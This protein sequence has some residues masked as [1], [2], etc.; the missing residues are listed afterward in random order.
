M[1]R[2]ILSTLGLA[3]MLVAAAPAQRRTVDDFFRDFTADWIRANPNQA[4]ALRYFTGE[5]QER[6][7]RELTPVNDAHTLKLI[8]LARKGLAELR[9]YDKSAMS[10][11][12]RVSA[13]VLQWQ[14]DSFIQM[15]PFRHIYFPFEQNGGVNVTLPSALTIQHPIQTERDADNYLEKLRQVDRAIDE[16][17]RDAR[18]LASTG[19][20]PPRFILDATI[21]QMKQFTATPPAD[22][23]LAATL[24]ERLAALPNI[25]P[26]KRD[27]VRIRAEGI[28]AGEVY[29]AW[30]RAV[31]FLESIAGR[32]THDAGVWRLPNGAEAYA[33][34][35]RRF[36]TT[37]LSA[38]EIHAIGLRMVNEIE[39]DM[40]RLLRKLG[41]T[42]GSVQSRI[43]RLKQ[44]QAYP[45]TEEG[46]KLIMADV[47]DLLRDAQRRSAEAFERQPRAAVVAR[48][49]PR[50]R[51]A[52]AAASYS[53]PS[54]DGSRPG[55]FQIPLRPDRMTKFGLRTLVY[56]ETV[57][58]H[59]FQIALDM[60]NTAQPRFRQLRAFGGFAALGEGWGLY[61]E[62]FAAESGWYAEDPVGLLG[63]LDGALFRARRLVVDT[64]LHAKRWTRQ[65]A[66]DYGISVSEVERYVVNPG[67]ACAYMIGQLKI[68]ELRE[69]ARARLGDKF[70]LKS[71]HTAV[72]NAGSVPLE[73]LEHAVE[74][75]I[76]V[77]AR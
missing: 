51:E 10:R 68:V 42:E 37:S 71:F 29:P 23:P 63:Q 11:E 46:R 15:E 9:S 26:S 16:A 73:I 19:I 48:P 61:A 1:R 22:N 50:F 67:Q 53:A 70:S 47:D 30:R 8:A 52:N 32:A 66:I 45:L 17:V 75:F 54:P 38:D 27:A 33:Y 59:H 69:R 65:Q 13:D 5:E 6:L 56:H 72:L 35:L 36:T 40:D 12:Q 3:V 34:T 18:S 74:D 20:L 41:R 49:F 76:E 31:T 62:R 58:G 2:V 39:Q 44:D 77:S 25:P 43:E 24:V 64:G 21:A 28:V 57:P 60:E 55:I 4:T 14:L 7:E